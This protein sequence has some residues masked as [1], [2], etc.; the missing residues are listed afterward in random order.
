M[1]CMSHLC[2]CFEKGVWPASRRDYLLVVLCFLGRRSGL[3]FFIP[4]SL[5]SD[6]TSPN[7]IQLSQSCTWAFRRGTP[8]LDSCKSK[9]SIY[10]WNGGGQTNKCIYDHDETKEVETK[11]VPCTLAHVFHVCLEGQLY[12]YPLFWDEMMYNR[13]TRN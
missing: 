9:D 11:N 1:T 8:C 7:H 2:L 12:Y 4:L 13:Y 10:G 6:S 3:F 5:V